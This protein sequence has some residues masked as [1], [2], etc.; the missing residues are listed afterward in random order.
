MM[1]FTFLY[2]WDGYYFLQGFWLDIKQLAS[3]ADSLLIAAAFIGLLALL[4]LLEIK[5]Y[6]P[7]SWF[8]IIVAAIYY[9][10]LLTVTLIGRAKG[11]VSSVDHLFE[12]Y[13]RAF[14]GDEAAR[15]D[16]LYNIVLYIPVGLLISH[17]RNNIINV[18]A[19]LLIPIGIEFLQ[20][21]T[22]RGV[23]EISDIINNFVGGLI[24]L[25]LARLIAKAVD[26]IKK[27]RKDGKVERTE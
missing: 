19:L 17:Y 26:I 27:K 1:D 12:T 14:G 8:Y 9:T 10:F 6:R 13:T 18:L 25:L 7:K 21:Y 23:F 15:L 2:Y 22:G 24:G 11:S 5:R 16:I 20:L 4:L 3:E